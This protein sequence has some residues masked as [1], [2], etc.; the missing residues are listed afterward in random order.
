MSALTDIINHIAAAP[1]R[2][3]VLVPR[4]ALHLPPFALLGLK[5]LLDHG[6]RPLA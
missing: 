4:L 5:P 1:G 3:A 2:S 6:H